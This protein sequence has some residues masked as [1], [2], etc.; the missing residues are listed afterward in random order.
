MREL[1]PEEKRIHIRKLKRFR[2]KYNRAIFRHTIGEVS[3]R[4]LV[5]LK[6]KYLIEEQEYISQS[7]VIKY[8]DKLFV[9]EEKNE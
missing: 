6:T 9:R 7:R 1:T 2:D 5:K 4:Q 8:F 3:S